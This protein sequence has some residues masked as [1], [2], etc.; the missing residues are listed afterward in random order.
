MS[1]PATTRLYMPHDYAPNG[2]EY[3]GQTTIA[4]QHNDN[5]HV[6]NGVGEGESVKNT[7]ATRFGK[8]RSGAAVSF[9]PSQY[10]RGSST[11]TREKWRGLSENT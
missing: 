8:R 3:A 10:A 5:V 11:N 1:R 2:L 9:S 4:A 6:H 7:H